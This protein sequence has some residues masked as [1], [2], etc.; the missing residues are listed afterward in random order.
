M[1]P[2]AP[3]LPAA[4]FPTGRRAETTIRASISS[5]SA[6]STRIFWP[7]SSPL[8]CVAVLAAVAAW[9]LHKP[10]PKLEGALTGERL[11]DIEFGPTIVD[12]RY[13]GKPKH[14]ARVRSSAVSKT[15]RSAPSASYWSSSSW[16]V[17]TESAS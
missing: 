8:A 15:R 2:Q 17:R 4:S 16:E 14:E 7:C 13:L 12:N 5:V 11:T 10:E 3:R 9:L 6:S 1:R